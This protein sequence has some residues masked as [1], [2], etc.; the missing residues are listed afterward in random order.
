M[1]NLMPTNKRENKLAPRE[2]VFEQIFD[3][4]FSGAFP[5]LGNMREQF[6]SFS[7]DVVEEDGAYRVTADLPGFKREDIQITYENNYLTIEAQNEEEVET[8][9][10]NYIRRERKYG[11]FRR[12]FFVEDIEDEAIDASF[13]NGLLK[14]ELK[15]E[16]PEIKTAKPIEIK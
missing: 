7:V 1:F 4:F 6:N 12:S 11:A 8:K 5:Q 2:D 9:E 13:D 15:K 14:I 10:K 16:T 3:N